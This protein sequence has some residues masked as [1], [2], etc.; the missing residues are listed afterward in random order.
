MSISKELIIGTI[1]SV[2]IVGFLAFNI[3]QY[4]Q[5]SNTT[6]AQNTSAA[7]NQAQAQIPNNTVLSLEEVKKHSSPQDCWLII[8][9]KVYSVSQYLSLHPGGAGRIT[10]YCGSDATQPFLTQGGEGKH[11]SQAF[12]DLGMLI[13]GNVNERITSQPNQVISS[14][15]FQERKGRLESEDE[16]ED[17][18]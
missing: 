8:E 10:P 5:L 6:G 14:P 7:Q 12:T 9:N 16:D 18:E 17:D 13:L 11:S 15:L 3:I 1:V 2:G 4:K